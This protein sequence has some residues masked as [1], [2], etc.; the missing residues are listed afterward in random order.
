MVFRERN[1]LLSQFYSWQIVLFLI[2]D[3]DLFEKI[4]CAREKSTQ[5]DRFREKLFRASVS[6]L[7]NFESFV[8]VTSKIDLCDF[9]ALALKTLNVLQDNDERHSCF[10]VEPQLGIAE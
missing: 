8:N 7:I 1:N 6:D 10:S 4:I 2:L 3:S 5:A 9:L